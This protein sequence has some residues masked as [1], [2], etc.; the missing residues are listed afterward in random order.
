MIVLMCIIGGGNTEIKCESMLRN[1]RK[2][3]PRNR[4]SENFLKIDEMV[5]LEAQCN[6]GND[7]EYK[8]QQKRIH[9]RQTVD[10]Y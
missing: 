6:L 10:I 4:E 7:N 2:A 8:T 9:Q 5:S 3:S 1:P